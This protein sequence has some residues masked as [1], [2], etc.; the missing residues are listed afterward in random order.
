VTIA[1]RME[2]LRKAAVYERAAWERTDQDLALFAEELRALARLDAVPAAG[3]TSAC[4][5]AR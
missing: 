5:C 4:V 2:L 1:E 3:C